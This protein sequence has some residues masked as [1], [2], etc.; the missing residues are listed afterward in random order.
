MEQLQQAPENPAWTPDI[1]NRKKETSRL[2]SALH[3]AESNQ[4]DQKEE[5]L[6]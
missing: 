6:G 4:V 5:D 3:S 2:P 1:A